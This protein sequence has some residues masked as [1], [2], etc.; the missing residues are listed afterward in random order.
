MRRVLFAEDRAFQHL[1]GMLRH[2][3]QGKEDPLRPFTVNCRTVL[4]RIQKRRTSFGERPIGKE[5]MFFGVRLNVF[6]KR[7]KGMNE[8]ERIPVHCR[9]QIVE[10]GRIAVRIG[11][12]GERFA[13][14]PLFCGGDE[15]RVV[16]ERLK[17]E[18]I[19][20]D[21]PDGDNGN[22]AALFERIKFLLRQIDAEDAL[23]HLFGASFFAR[24]EKENA[25]PRLAK[26]I[27]ERMEEGKVVRV[28]K[29]AV[30]LGLRYII[31]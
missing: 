24:G 18:R 9:A 4:L 8:K 14:E 5:I 28:L 25:V 11:G 22:K 15:R 3:A 27:L 30:A 1:D 16:D 23:G 6:L 29:S 12:I 2:F 10:I 21:H 17:K 13:T 20:H 19:V 26:G 31:G 7:G